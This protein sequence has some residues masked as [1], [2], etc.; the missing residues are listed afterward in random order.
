MEPSEEEVERFAATFRRFT[1]A[2]AQAAPGERVSPVRGLIDQHVGADTSMTPIL[3]ESFSSW[4]HANVQ[5]AVSAWLDE[6]ERSHEL[7]GL[8]GQQRHFS[9]LSDMLDTANWVQ[10]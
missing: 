9:S 1:E 10:V 3:S 7:V 8:T 5:V 2:M 4:D 6:A